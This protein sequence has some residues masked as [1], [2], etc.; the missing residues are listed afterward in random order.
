MTDSLEV[1][2]LKAKLHAEFDRFV[3][4]LDDDEIVST[5]RILLTA[6]ELRRAKRRQKLLQGGVE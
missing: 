6:K 3:H 2:K 5:D 1:K 4:H